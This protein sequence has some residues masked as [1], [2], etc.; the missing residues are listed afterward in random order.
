MTDTAVPPLPQ[1]PLA[2]PRRLRRADWTRRLVAENSL[3]V[4]DLI[5]PIFVHDAAGNVPIPSMPG[6][7][8]LSVDSAVAAAR[9]AEQLGIPAIAL[10]PATDPKL[11]TD[12]AGYYDEMK[13]FY[14]NRFEKADG[15]DAW[16]TANTAK[17]IVDPSTPIVPVVEAAPAVAPAATT[18]AAAATPAVTTP[19]KPAATAPA[20][21]AATK[22]ATTPA[23]PAGNKPGN[24]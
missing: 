8:R 12:A 17:P 24:K 22:P 13:K 21:P 3:S 23:K 19:A 16:V 15:L 2:R 11:K 18:P 6:V 7:E 5:W 1:F 20:K 10:F 9:E 4:N 14:Q